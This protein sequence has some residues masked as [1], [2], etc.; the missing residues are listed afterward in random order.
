MGM[1]LT[2]L[3][4]AGFVAALALVVPL[5]AYGLSAFVD[6]LIRMSR[7]GD[8][9]EGLGG[10]RGPRRPSPTGP[11]TSATGSPGPETGDAPS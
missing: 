1:A 11:S 9:G 8:D 10:L 3:G 4:M 5:L 2:L 6:W 7:G